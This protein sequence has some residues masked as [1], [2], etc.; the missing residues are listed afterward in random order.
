MYVRMPSVSRMTAMSRCVHGLGETLQAQLREDPAYAGVG[1]HDT[2]RNHGGPKFFLSGLGANCDIYSYKPAPGK[3]K[4][5]GNALVINL[6]EHSCKGRRSDC[7]P[8]PRDLLFPLQ[9]ARFLGRDVWV[10]N[11]PEAYLR[12]RYGYLGNDA[13]PRRDDTGLYRPA[14]ASSSTSGFAPRVVPLS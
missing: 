3:G 13:A 4:G 9:K 10:P 7:V 8:V 11:Q 12:L 6:G 2:S 5:K 1:L 14:V